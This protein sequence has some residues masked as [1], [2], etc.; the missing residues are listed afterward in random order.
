MSTNSL[1]KGCSLRC[2]FPDISNVAHSRGPGSPQLLTGK[3]KFPRS[4]QRKSICGCGRR[5]YSEGRGTRH[6]LQVLLQTP[7]SLC[8]DSGTCVPHLGSSAGVFCVPSSWLLQEA[9]QLSILRPSLGLQEG[10]RVTELGRRCP[11][12]RRN[13]SGTSGGAPLPPT[14]CHLE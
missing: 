2:Q 12:R 6:V 3:P 14:S 8:R 10:K 7:C 5:G 4:P 11:G 13:S 9:T 1:V